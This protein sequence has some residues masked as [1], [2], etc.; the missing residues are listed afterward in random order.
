MRPQGRYFGALTS[1]LVLPLLFFFLRDEP[2]ASLVF[3]K[4]VHL[5]RQGVAEDR[6]ARVALVYAT[7]VVA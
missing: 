1:D 4:E 6:V 5:E 7:S 3:L 2:F